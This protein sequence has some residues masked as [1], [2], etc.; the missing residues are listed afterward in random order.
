MRLFLDNV[1][2]SCLH[3]E[4]KCFDV[5]KA[6]SINQLLKGHAKELVQT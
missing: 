5:A 6:F 4:Q 1:V 2:E 3:C